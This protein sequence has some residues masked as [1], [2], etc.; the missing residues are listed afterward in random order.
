[1]KNFLTIDNKQIPWPIIHKQ[2]DTEIVVPL[3]EDYNFDDMWYLDT[4]QA[5]LIFEKQADII[6][7][8]QSKGIID[9]GCRHGPVNEILYEKGYTEYQYMGFD[10]SIEPIQI[11]QNI[12]QQYSN[13]EYRHASWNNKNNI[14][15]EFDVDMVIFSGV[16]LYMK[17]DH[18]TLFNDMINLY[19]ATNAIIQE[20]YHEQ[21][22]WD[23]RLVLQTI[24]K[25]MFLYKNKYKKYKEYL[26]DC[27]I[28]LG[29]RLVAD[30]CI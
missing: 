10:T 19:K 26:V 13:I 12:W 21:R 18:F 29:K 20:P 4:P 11:G 3:I 6:I 5:K 23:T 22:Y 2:T 24:T 27:E 28:F 14:L 17:N 7:E 30:I 16:L 8:K 25:E 15:V 1:M 9:I